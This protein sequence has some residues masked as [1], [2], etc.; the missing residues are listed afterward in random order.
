MTNQRL[1]RIVTHWLMPLSRL[2]F[3]ACQMYNL[4]SGKI[5]YRLACQVSTKTKWGSLIPRPLKMSEGLSTSKR[6]AEGKK[7]LVADRYLPMLVPTSK[8]DK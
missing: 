3:F 4:G 1:N 8:T 2:F 6:Q 5:S 7:R